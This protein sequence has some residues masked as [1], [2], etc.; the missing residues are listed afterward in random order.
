MSDFEL[1]L[2]EGIR[3]ISDLGA[4]DHILFI[5]ALCAIYQLADWRRL[6]VLVTAFTLGHSATLAL[7]ALKI[8]QFPTAVIEFLIPITILITSLV[9]ILG[10]NQRAPRVWPR[11]VM[12]AFFGLI[13]GLGFS[14]YLQGLLGREES[15]VVPLF[16]FNLGLEIG[17]LL[18]VA[19]I[20]FVTTLLVNG[21]R[22]KMRDWTLVLSGGVAGIAL[23]LIAKTW[24]F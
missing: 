23:T 9:N 24:I 11:Y 13:H 8:V 7:A 21:F 22:A 1:Y 18:I 10:A 15:I 17:Q 16:A 2:R 20:L 19:V 6:L 4:Y 12:A 14:N 3:H 5:T